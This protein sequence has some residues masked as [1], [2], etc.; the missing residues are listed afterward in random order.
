M[1][2]AKASAVEP[3]L[4]VVNVGANITVL[5]SAE[6]AGTNSHDARDH[7]KLFFMRYQNRS[8]L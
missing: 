5:A 1:Y 7:G 3:A 2:C 6:P 4:R 8:R